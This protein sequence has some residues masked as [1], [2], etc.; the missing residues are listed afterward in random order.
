MNMKAIWAAGAVAAA[1]C[2]LGA[3]AE[4]QP[5]AEPR[6]AML[7]KLVDCRKITDEAGRLACYDQATAAL[8]QAEAKGDI[9]VVDREQA[10]K[11]RRQAFGFSM[12]SLSLFE[13]GE[14]QEEIQNVQGVVAE[15]RIN[16]AGKWVIKLQDGATWAQVDPGELHRNPK[17]GMT[18]KI[19]Q[20]SLGSYL[21]SIDN[22]GAFRARRVE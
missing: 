20:A 8:D 11:V 1:I 7:Q 6:S 9:V 16:N 18:V 22:M 19:R 14:T 10:R 12:P 13:K 3:T 17:P 15:A 4:A 5:K 2:A 21:M